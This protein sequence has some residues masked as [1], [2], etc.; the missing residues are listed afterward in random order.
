MSCGGLHCAGC[1]GGA[2]VPVV[3]LAAFCGLAWVAEHLIEVA[4]VS[5]ACGILF[6]AAVVALMR[7]TGRRE[8]AF[9]RALAV[10]SQPATLTATVTPQ[11]TYA[12]PPAVEQHVHYHVHVA[13]APEAA[14]VI[15]TALP[16]TAGDK[17]T[18]E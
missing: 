7:W 1:A 15:R 14:R 6:V 3:P 17:I 5:A 13:A 16:G 12:K 2:A 4:I 11:V 10:R 18:E 8:A 9:A